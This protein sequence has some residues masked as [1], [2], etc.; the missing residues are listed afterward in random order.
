MINLLRYELV[1]VE[2]LK[3]R[4]QKFIEKMSFMKVNG[5][6]KNSNFFYIG[7]I[8]SYRPVIHLNFSFS[9]SITY[10]IGVHE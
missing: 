3:S 9:I 2:V 7:F 4:G 8:L 1:W 10:N 6:D 5:H